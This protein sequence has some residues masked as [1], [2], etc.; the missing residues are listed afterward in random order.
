MG[1]VFAYGH[2]LDGALGIGQELSSYG[3][4]PTL[5]EFFFDNLVVIKQI[6]CGGDSLTGVHSAAV[7]QDGSLF[8]WGVGVALGTGTLRSAS[9]PKRVELPHSE[10]VEE[11][12]NNSRVAVQSVS[13]GSGFCVAISR[14]GQAFSWGKW[15]DGRLGL[16]PI[17]IL[18]K[19][20]R[21]HGGGAVRKQFQ[22]FQ[23]H[24][25][26]IETLF[27]EESSTG[28]SEDVL[29]LKVDCGDAHCVG[30]T[31]EGGLVTWGR[32]GSGQQGRG[33]ISDTF[34]PTIVTKLT[35]TRWRDVAAGENWSMA[36]SIDGQ[37]W[38]WGGCGAAVLGHGLQGSERNTLLAQTVLQRH[39]HFLSQGK[40][41]SNALSSPKLPQLRWMVPQ[42]ISC[43][44]TP[45]I[46]ICRLSAGT[47]HAAAISDTGDL[48]MW[49]DG[50]PETSI[51]DDADTSHFVLS[52]LPKLVNSGQ[53]VCVDGTNE[54]DIGT[55]SVEH[56]VCGGRKAIAFTSG[57]FL[58]RSM[59]K[60]YHNS[61]ES[62]EE[63]ATTESD[64]VLVV[65]GQRLQ[66]HKLLLAQRSPVLRELILE[67]EQHRRSERNSVSGTDPMELLLT[68]LR[69]DVARALLEYIYTD[70]FTLEVSKNSYF[71]LRDVLRAAKLFKLPG[72]VK[73]CRARL[74]SASP[75]SLF[76]AS[77]P[78]SMLDGVAEEDML[79]E[80]NSEDEAQEDVEDP[81]KDPRTLNED[82]K[83]ALSDDVWADTV[84]LAEG[85]R[86]PVHRC[87]LIARSE[88]FRALLAFNRSAL[89][90]DSE[91]LDKK[92]TLVKVEDTYA[93]IVRVLRFIYY[94]QVVLPQLKTKA[95]DSEA[96]TEAEQVN[97]Q[98][99]E[100][101]VA[102]D[103]YGLER[104]KRLCEHAIEVTVVN[105]LDV[106]AVA[107]LVHASHLKQVAMSYLRTH[108]AAVTAREEEFLRFQQSFP[109]VLEELYISLRDSSQEEVL[110]RE[111]YTDVKKSLDAQ[112][113]ESDMQW[114]KKSAAAA[115]P[116]IPLSFTIVFGT[117]YLSMMHTQEHELP[118]VPATN[119]VAVAGIVVAIFMG[120]L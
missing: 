50:Y 110:L 56:V 23:L 33:N 112:R 55:H 44:S 66:A 43:F 16:G 72:L 22:M 26:R 76:G 105:C 88:Y 61:N 51:G 87:M 73:L 10:A 2:N 84:L 62:G 119:L 37:V 98:L 102:A 48:Y 25:K 30:L 85:H 106:L 99:L 40:N 58:S 42:L 80:S 96:E 59:S 107:D 60:L 108:L 94:D 28:R 8:T 53:R 4:Q 103:K 18:V 64:L 45:D 38:S 36:L 34:S 69:A 68:Q 13:C 15:A 111:W 70:N 114:T 109:R 86:I 52:S 118:A 19:M 31:I 46:R 20:S 41:A 83:F 54:A 93:G 65:S 14:E 104:M 100:D 91:L 21:R 63:T 113:E 27:T 77:S 101:L 115:F 47:Q 82:M 24:P 6:A 49:G 3:T 12:S 97:D 9:T 120:Y 57:S 95:D 39:Q 5:V 71:L 117:L 32:G 92:M 75:A 35:G 17:P 90:T 81:S 11:D 1:L 29:F 7:D 79:D 89:P 78:S 116:W 74:F 67:E